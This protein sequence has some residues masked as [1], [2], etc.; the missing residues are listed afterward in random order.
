MRAKL[1]PYLLLFLACVSAWSSSLN[2]TVFPVVYAQ[3]EIG[4][5]PEAKGVLPEVVIK[6]KESAKVST[7]KPELRLDLDPLET[8]QESLKTEESLLL[9]S[10]PSSLTWKKA[11]PET[12]YNKRVVQP[13]RS[14][15]SR[16]PRI[17]FKLGS[18]LERILKRPLGNKEGKRY[19]WNLS[20]VD[21]EGRVFQRYEGAG[22]LPKEILWNGQN[23]SGEWI[24]AGY[25]YSAIYTFTDLLGTTHTG[26][27][28]PLKFSGIVY[29]DDKGLHL[30]LDTGVLFGAQKS[31]QEIQKPNG[32]SLIRAAADLV[33]RYYYGV[34]MQVR[35]FA[36]SR[37]LAQ[38]QGAA[39]QRYFLSELML[40]PQMVSLES[41][42]AGYT[43]QR[44][45]VLLL[46][47]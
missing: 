35:V 17:A 26:V 46:N 41:E 11:T 30:S 28:K 47:Q 34:P 4:S 25:T 5:Q 40:N 42:A 27:G 12:L 45:E 24:R 33:K 31:E 29:Q 14:T 15:L 23:D 44:V 43:N 2:S 3:G 16:Q 9:V 32:E 22:E 20:I 6:A 13:A 18:E 37:D 1:F 8:I 10:P 38:T 7:P 19:R 39:V 21:E 36:G